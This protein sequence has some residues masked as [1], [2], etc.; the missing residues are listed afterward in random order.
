MCVRL[1]GSPAGTFLSFGKHLK[2]STMDF[3]GFILWQCGSGTGNG[4]L[5]RRGGADGEGWIVTQLG[6][7]L[8]LFLLVGERFIS[9]WR[10]ITPR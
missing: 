10:R 3:V 5:V 7:G 9:R 1:L 2:L 8:F 4:Y 6:H